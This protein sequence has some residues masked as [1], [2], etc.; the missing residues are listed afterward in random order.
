MACLAHIGGL[1]VRRAFA[2]G[3]GA[4]VTAETVV[5]DVR[6]VE[7]RRRPRNG[8]MTVVAVVATGDVRRMLTGCCHSVMAGTAGAKHL[9]VINRVN[10]YPDVRGMAVFANIAR[11]KMGRILARCIRA[12]MAAGTVAGN[13]DVIEIRR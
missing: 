5:Y 11:L 12:V 7:R 1:H 13:V 3:V 2:G 4:V 8:R 6:V 10:G 9:R